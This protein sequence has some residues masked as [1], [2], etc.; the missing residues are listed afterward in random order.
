MCNSETGGRPCYS[1]SMILFA[2]QSRICY[3]KNITKLLKH[4][5]YIEIT[6]GNVGVKYNWNSERMEGIENNQ[7]VERKITVNWKKNKSEGIFLAE[8]IW[9]LSYPFILSGYITWYK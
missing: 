8:T 1:P 2:I 5:I 4:L 9:L 7:Q 3:G 6:I